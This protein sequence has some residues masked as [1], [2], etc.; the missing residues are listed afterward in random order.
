MHEVHSFETHADGRGT[1]GP[2]L[3]S[4]A[5][6]VTMAKLLI[7]PP[8]PLLLLT[9]RK[10][11]RA[12]E[13]VVV[14]WLGSSEGRAAHVQNSLTKGDFGTKFVMDPSLTNIRI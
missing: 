14:V 7:K 5:H 4:T 12:V 2:A 3:S 9:L 10:G 8:I 1:S 6:I 11:T 13:R